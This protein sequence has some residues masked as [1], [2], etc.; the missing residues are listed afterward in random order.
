MGL[1]LELFQDMIGN[2]GTL[3]MAAL[4]FM[5]VVVLGRQMK[6]EADCLQHLRADAFPMSIDKIDC[7][8]YVNRVPVFVLPG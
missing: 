6:L 1:G 7:Q 4:S 2:N 5:D 8:Y 3:A